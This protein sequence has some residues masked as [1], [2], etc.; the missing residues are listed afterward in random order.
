MKKIISLMLVVVLAVFSIIP[1]LATTEDFKT[2]YNEFL[3]YVDD[4]ELYYI[5]DYYN[6]PPSGPLWSNASCNRII[7]AVEFV[8]TSSVS[9]LDELNQVEAEFNKVVSSMCVDKRELEFMISLFE[10]EINIDSYYDNETW[11]NF[12]T[13]LEE[14]K[15][16]LDSDDEKVIH[17]TYIKMRNTFNDICRYNTEYGDFNGDGRLSVADITLG[18]KYLAQLL[19]F[20]SSQRT[21]SQFN[22]W[23]FL[24]IE[25]LTDLQK[26]MVGTGEKMPN[27]HLQQV[28]ELEDL[29]VNERRFYLDYENANFVYHSEHSK[30]FYSR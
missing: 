26:Y 2:Q 1:V 10:K 29:D 6:I 25:D 28:L 13:V 18:Q 30:Y 21:I 9:T 11:N 20:N 12:Q 4:C 14:G 19:Q 17:R 16:V 24:K 3:D 22:Y 7:D 8:R 5:Y 27:R 15:L 23:N